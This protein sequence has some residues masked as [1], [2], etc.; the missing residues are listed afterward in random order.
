MA[1]VMD[2]ALG[3]AASI[4]LNALLGGKAHEPLSA[5]SHRCNWKLAAVIDLFTT[6]GHCY[7][8]FVRNTAAEEARWSV[9]VPPAG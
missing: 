2:T 4:F 3:V 5:R 8:S 7:R 6:P 9:D 1:K